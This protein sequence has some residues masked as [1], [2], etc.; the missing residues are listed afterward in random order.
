[1]KPYDRMV[2]LRR[3]HWNIIDNGDEELYEVWITYGVPDEP[4]DDILYDIATDVEL[5]T[6]ICELYDRLAREF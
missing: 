3:M 6:E 1:M 5:Y 2:N 4:N